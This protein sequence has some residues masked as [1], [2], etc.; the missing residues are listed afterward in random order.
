M[1]N[2]QTQY[3]VY[4]DVHITIGI[5]DIPFADYPASKLESDP[6]AKAEFDKIAQSGDVTKRELLSDS[7]RIRL[8]YKR[9]SL[10]KLA[11]DILK[12]ML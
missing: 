5:N 11:A 7:S 2:T 3:I 8:Y 10:D 4:H 12:V 1:P 6:K 9:D